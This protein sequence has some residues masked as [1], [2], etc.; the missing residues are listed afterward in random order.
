MDIII[1]VPKNLTVV[2]LLM[3]PFPC[4]CY[5]F[6]VNVLA[7]TLSLLTGCNFSQVVIIKFS[8]IYSSASQPLS[9]FHL[10]FN[11]K[12]TCAEIEAKLDFISSI[13]VDNHIHRVDVN[14]WQWLWCNKIFQE[15]NA[16]KALADILGNNGMHIKSCY[17]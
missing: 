4:Q 7:K 12:K 9:N 13:W 11:N 10:L 1:Y 14:N 8:I 6:P 16:T 15:I 3:L 5:I 2:F 17:A